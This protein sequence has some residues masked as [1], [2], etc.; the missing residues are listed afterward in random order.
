MHCT[1]THHP[2]S[3]QSVPQTIP[4]LSQSLSHFNVTPSTT[5]CNS[6]STNEAPSPP[7]LNSLP[8]SLP[9]Q[10]MCRKS[11]DA[12]QS[13][14]YKMRAS[15]VNGLHGERRL[16]AFAQ[17]KATLVRPSAAGCP[18]AQYSLEA[19]LVGGGGGSMSRCGD[20][21]RSVDDGGRRSSFR[22]KITSPSSDGCLFI[23]SVSGGLGE[24]SMT[25]ALRFDRPG[26]A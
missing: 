17:N 25:L 7:R 15:A 13:N 26:R 4:L 6:K 2:V 21:V 10:L 22:L 19:M 20:S 14:G 8:M 12:R 3:S 23:G 11:I 24:R 5:T 9:I 16:N 1:T 18:D